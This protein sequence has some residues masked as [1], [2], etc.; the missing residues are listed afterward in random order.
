M[1][2]FWFILV[3][4]ARRFLVT[5]SWNGRL[6]ITSDTG[7]KN[8]S[9]FKIWKTS[10]KAVAWLKPVK[11]LANET[12]LLVFKANEQARKVVDN[13]IALV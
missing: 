2:T 5:W 4:R 7:D 11:F 3:A 8:D 10:R 6:Q 9:G 13:S 1:I 12:P